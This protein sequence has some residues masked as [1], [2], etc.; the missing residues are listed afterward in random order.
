MQCEFGRNFQFHAGIDYLVAFSRQRKMTKKYRDFE[1]KISPRR[2]IQY[3][4]FFVRKIFSYLSAKVE[5]IFIPLNLLIRH[6]W[7]LQMKDMKQLLFSTEKKNFNL[8]RS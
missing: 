1:K 7:F 6:E 8:K 5:T 3:C 4:S 2:D